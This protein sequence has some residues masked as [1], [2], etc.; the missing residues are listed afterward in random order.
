MLLVAC[1]FSI[2]AKT[3]AHVK[4]AD[5]TMA[6]FNASYVQNL[7][8]LQQSGLFDKGIQALFLDYQINETL[9]KEK[10]E[11]LLRQ[12]AENFVDF[13]N[14]CETIQ[15]HLLVHPF[16]AKEV[17]I[18][19]HTSADLGQEGALCGAEISNNK[20]SYYYKHSN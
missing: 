13:V 18:S 12:L 4:A 14:H 8:P 3:P 6:A 1:I 7:E 10:A 17:S 11:N 19:I 9:T 16:T 2:F 15:P 5:E 20:I